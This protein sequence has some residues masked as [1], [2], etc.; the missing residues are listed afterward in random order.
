M[1][2][3]SIAC[4]LLCIHY[5]WYDLC[6]Y[7]YTECRGKCKPLY[8]LYPLILTPQSILNYTLSDIIILMMK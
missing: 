7:K 2:K 8:L 1:M 6:F 5:N 4:H 3:K